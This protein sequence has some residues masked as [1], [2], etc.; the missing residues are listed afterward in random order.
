METPALR[1][2]AENALRKL[3][4]LPLEFGVK[5]EEMWASSDR[6]YGKDYCL[7]ACQATERRHVDVLWL[8]PRGT[9]KHFHL[10]H[11]LLLEAGRTKCCRK[12]VFILIDR[13]ERRA[14]VTEFWET[15]EI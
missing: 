14:N 3:L 4:P 9:R 11:P 2:R 13:M 5:E 6:T 10:V 1:Q 8:G 7:R 15:Q 12:I